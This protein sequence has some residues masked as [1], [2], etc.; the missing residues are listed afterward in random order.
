MKKAK[1]L[2]KLASYLLSLCFLFATLTYALPTYVLGETEADFVDDISFS[3]PENVFENK[4]ILSADDVPE[5]IDFA[6]AQEKGH[7]L[8]LRAKETD[9][10]TVIFLNN[11]L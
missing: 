5:A 9:E 6:E 3:T 10:H 7:V 11:M 4:L 1:T 2:S 8:R